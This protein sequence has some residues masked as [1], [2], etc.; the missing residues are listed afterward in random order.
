[1]QLG[2]RLLRTGALLRLTVPRY[3]QDMAKRE[4]DVVLH[5]A[6]GFVG[7]LTAIHLAEHHGQAKV[8]LSGRSKDKLEALRDELKVDWPLIVVDANDEESLASLAAS[9]VAI[10]TTVGP[11]QKYGMPLVRA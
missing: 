9:T 1:P 11:Y 5:G 3:V 7:R 6:T 8:A 2:G 4:H 10:A